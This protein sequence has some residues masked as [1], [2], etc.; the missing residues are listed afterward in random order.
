MPEN[1]YTAARCAGKLDI[2]A[3]GVYSMLQS[4]RYVEGRSVMQ[5]SILI[6]VYKA[7]SFL[8]KTVQSALAQEG[9]FEI[10]LVE[11]GSPDGSGALIDRLAAEHPERI[12]GI[13]RPHAG[14]IPTRRAAI[15]AARGEYIV[16]LDA[17]DFLETD[18]LTTYAKA[19]EADP[20]LDIIV[21]ENRFLY[22]DGRTP[23]TR[24]P[25]FP[26]GTVFDGEEEKHALY[27]LYLR[28]NRLD[29]LWGKCFRTR[30]FQEDPTDYSPY[31][32]NSIG[33]DAIQG[34][35]PFTAAKRV[36]YLRHSVY[37]YLLQNASITHE[38]DPAKLDRQFNRLKFRF[39]VPFMKKWGLYDREH[40]VLL[41]ASAYKTIVDNVLYYW[42]NGYDK[43]AIRTYV[44]EFVD[45]HPELA[46]LSR[47][48]VLPLKHRV[49]F[50]LFRMK[51][52]E[53]IEGGY[54]LFRTLHDAKKKL[55][56]G[57]AC[58][59]VF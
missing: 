47:S 11:D 25:L 57:D 51:K 49:V 17:D 24:D 5:F 1:L 20:S 22:P 37:G 39:F 58:V 41:K 9:D 36:L 54:Q 16:W 55:S 7:E 3:A 50:T 44:S 13:H 12:R 10:V 35:Y 8:E 33:E 15:A 30:L 23:K 21:G 31:F 43:A 40:R 4:L 19:L 48:T 6:P 34:L 14:T 56:G 26:D 45:T 18:T 38:F 2:F 59:S 32:V 27:E 29:S 52:P 28:G 53:L 46:S 42:E